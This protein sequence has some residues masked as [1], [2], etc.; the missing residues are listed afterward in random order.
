MQICSEHYEPSLHREVVMSTYIDRPLLSITARAVR[1]IRD[2]A[3]LLEPIDPD[4][5]TDLRRTIDGVERRAV[6]R[7][8]TK[9]REEAGR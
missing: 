9:A 7:A 3:T 6:L 4:G 1:M 2:A 5:A 8:D